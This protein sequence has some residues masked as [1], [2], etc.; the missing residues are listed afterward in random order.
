MRGIDRYESWENCTWFFV[1]ETFSFGHS[2]VAVY[3]IMLPDDNYLF[4]DATGTSHHSKNNAVGQRLR[5]WPSSKHSIGSTSC[6]FWDICNVM[7][8]SGYN[9]PRGTS[10][11]TLDFKRM[12][13]IPWGHG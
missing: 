10:C 2:I 7:L 5:C 6:H 4:T 3:N 8:L 1:V 11:D 12:Q 13:I 9:N